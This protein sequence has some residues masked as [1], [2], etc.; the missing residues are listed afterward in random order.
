MDKIGYS[1]AFLCRYGLSKAAASNL[2][3]ICDERGLI[4]KAR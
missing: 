2:I 3:Y 4:T 1:I